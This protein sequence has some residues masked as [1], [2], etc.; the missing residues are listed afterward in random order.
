MESRN[1][2]WIQKMMEG[3][4]SEEESDR[5]KENLTEEDLGFFNHL[6]KVKATTGD[7]SI[8]GTKTREEAWMQLMEKMADES[9]KTVTKVVPFY[10]NPQFVSWIAASVAILVGVYFFFNY[11]GEKHIYVPNAKMQ[12]VVFPD[13]SK[14][15]LNA[16]SR[17]K[18]D[19]RN[20][21]KNRSVDLDGEAFF[22]IK[23]GE[24]FIVNTKK[25]SVFVLGTSF[26]VLRRGNEFQVKCISGR[27]KVVLK[28]FNKSIE[29]IAGQA[30]RLK[31][32][33]L[34]EPYTVDPQKIAAWQ[35]GEFYFNGDPLDLVISELERQFDVQIKVDNIE[36]RIYTGHFSNN[37]L[38]KALELVLRPMDLEYDLIDGKL[39]IVR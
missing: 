20:F 7:L 5:L 16:H 14:A 3:Q 34:T 8:T 2:D 35:E 31:D 36:D 28:D 12:A 27:V 15:M 22:E 4:L 18:F 39:V 24:P 37:D 6:E 11:F 23:A 13:E 19:Q 1:E 38:K 10:Q 26:N 17:L 33:V 21:Y 32:K 9:V 25:G 30:T 29:L